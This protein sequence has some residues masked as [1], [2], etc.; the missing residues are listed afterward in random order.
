MASI[1]IVEDITVPDTEATRTT[2]QNDPFASPAQKEGSSRVDRSV[3][4][5]S[6]ISSIRSNVHTHRSGSTKESI[7][8]Q[9]QEDEPAD[10]AAMYM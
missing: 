6:R 4:P 2:F 8:S 3:H 9:K 10:P 7:A 1:N 5:G